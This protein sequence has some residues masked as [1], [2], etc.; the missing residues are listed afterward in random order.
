MAVVI[1][2]EEVKD[3]FTTSASDAEIQLAIDLIDQA[4]ACLDKNN[5]PVKVQ[6]A[7]KLYGA[8]AILWAQSNGGRGSV[9]S[10]TAPSGASRSYGQWKGQYGPY[11]DMI[12][13]FDQ[14]GCVRSILDNKQSLY[15]RSVG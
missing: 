15:I 14:Y 7:L 2:V 1:T 6:T 10:E 11:W 5:V 3:S 8:R 13:N 12:A 4:D 9:T